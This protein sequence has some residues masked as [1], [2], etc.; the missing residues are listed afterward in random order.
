MSLRTFKM[1]R[2]LIHQETGIWLRDNKEVMLASRLARRLRDLNLG[3]F[4]EYFAY[5]TS[6]AGGSAELVELINCVTTNK[7]SFFREHH[8]FEF[9]AKQTVNQPSSDRSVHVWSA[10]CSTGE[11]PYSIAISLLEA[12]QGIGA[13]SISEVKIFASDI[14]TKVLETAKRGTYNEHVMGPMPESLLKK[15]FLKG[16]GASAGQ[17]RVKRE[18]AEVIEFHRI[19]LIEPAWPIPT[20]LDAIFFRNALIYFTQETQEKILR[21]MVTFL[22]PGGYL[23]LGH[24]ENVPWLHDLV[25]PLRNTIYQ[26]KGVV[27]ADDMARPGIPERVR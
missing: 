10:A 20:G 15:Y 26:R 23:F 25:V 13:R 22:K 8:H 21:R 11:E 3:G 16:K 12:R 14:D 19:N 7:T 1:F 27:A 4:E 17:V 6:G 2:A 24:S 5:A 18:I 9:L